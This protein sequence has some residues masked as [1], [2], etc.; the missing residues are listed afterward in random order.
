MGIEPTSSAWKADIL[1]DVRY[2][3]CRNYYS[4]FCVKCPA[5]I[6]YRK[7]LQKSRRQCFLCRFTSIGTF[8]FAQ[9]FHKQKTLHISVQRFVLVENTGIEPVTSC[10][11][12]KRSP[13]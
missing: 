3:H 4:M 8:S 10:M 7:N 1:A 12:C 11:P 9:H 13:S 6:S 2:P 5:L